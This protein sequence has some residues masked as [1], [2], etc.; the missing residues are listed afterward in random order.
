MK[1]N[2]STR[3]IANKLW[4]LGIVVTYMYGASRIFAVNELSILLIMIR[5]LILTAVLSKFA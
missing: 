4:L 5:D 2:T 3:H 1:N